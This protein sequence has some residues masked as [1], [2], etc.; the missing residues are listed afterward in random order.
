MEFTKIPVL[1]DSPM[2][3]ITQEEIDEINIFQKDLPQDYLHYVNKVDSDD[4]NLLFLARHYGIKTRFLDVTYDPLVA[5][6]FACSANFEDNGYIYFMLNTINVKE[7][8][9]ITS[10]Y[11]KAYDFDIDQHVT[12]KDHYKHINFLY[13]FPYSNTRVN[14]QKGA[15]LFNYDPRKCLSDGTMI[16]EIPFD[17]KRDILNHLK[18]LNISAETLGL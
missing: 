16:Y 12:M 17:K 6:Y 9:I 14:A 15:F 4:I 11:K 18:F 13:T 5:L 2:S 8:H 10:D 1:E 7:Q 3:Y